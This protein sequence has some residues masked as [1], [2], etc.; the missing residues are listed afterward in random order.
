MFTDITPVILTFNE[1][2]NIA[3][4]LEPL[5]WAKEI[6]VVDSYSTDM[7]LDIINNYPNV[8]L[9][10]RKF[11]R[12]ADQWNYATKE[13]GI[14]TE[15]ILALDA[16]YVLTNDVVTEIKSLKPDDST[17]GYEASFSYC[18]FGHPLR[19]TLYPP[20]TVLYR[21][22]DD[23]Y[24]QDG[25]T[26][27]IQISG[28]I[29]QLSEKILH[30]D[31]KTLSSWLQAQDRYMEL[32]ADIISKSTFGKLGFND[33]VRKLIFIAPPLTLVFCLVGKLGILDG[34]RGL[35]YA[36]QR[37]L[38]ELLLSL[39]LIERIIKIQKLNDYPRA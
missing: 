14:E 10:Q 11:D 16:D 38:A 24:V 6:I 12:H 18:I 30:D 15:W 39:K 25:H 26:Q 31:R 28:N 36:S 13:T 17:S 32:E 21:R 3:R 1:E 33:R 9:F 2:A 23:H 35:Y 22:G 5:V 7:T 34:W 4:V 20:V 27:R 37:T 19:G 29:S 8:R